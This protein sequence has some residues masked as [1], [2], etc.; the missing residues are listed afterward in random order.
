MFEQPGSFIAEV[1]AQDF[2]AMIY[3]VFVIGIIMI[4]V[5]FMERVYRI[6]KKWFLWIILCPPLALIFIKQNW[7]ETRAACFFFFCFYL[8]IILAGALTGYKMT[9]YTTSL[10]QLI[11]LWPIF[12]TKWLN[13]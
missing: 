1:P 4:L 13:A 12:L 6:N 2:A 3:W 7:D 8:I 11:F 9:L 10:L 5:Y